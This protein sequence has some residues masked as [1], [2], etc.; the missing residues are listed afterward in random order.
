MPI[1]DCCREGCR[2][3][4]TGSP[5]V[6]TGDSFHPSDLRSEDSSL[7]PCL[8]PLGGDP[9]YPGHRAFCS[10]DFPL[11][12]MG[13]A[14]V[15]PPGMFNYTMADRQRL[16]KEVVVSFERKGKKL[17]MALPAVLTHLGKFGDD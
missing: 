13:G 14:T 7:W 15:R 6:Y 9:G 17:Q 5:P 16:I 11:R 3:R 10:L 1:W 2:P 12:Q 8:A 4:K